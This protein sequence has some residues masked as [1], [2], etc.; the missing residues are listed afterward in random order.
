MLTG[1]TRSRNERLAAT[2]ARRLPWKGVLKN[3]M[4]LTTHSLDCVFTLCCSCSSPCCASSRAC[5][6]QLRQIPMVKSKPYLTDNQ[7]PETVTNEEKRSFMNWIF[8]R[9]IFSVSACK[10]LSCFITFGL[11][12]EIAFSNPRAESTMLTGTLSGSRTLA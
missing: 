12:M 3:T 8:L 4:P 5:N 7:T 11:R 2:L 1:K 6:N 10:Y 9:T